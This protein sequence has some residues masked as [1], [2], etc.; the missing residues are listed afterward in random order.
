[1]SRQEK[2]YLESCRTVVNEELYLDGLQSKKRKLTTELADLQGK[3]QTSKRHLQSHKDKMQ[4]LKIA[5]NKGKQFKL[6]HARK[7]L[8]FEEKN[9]DDEI[10][11]AV[12]QALE[13]HSPNIVKDESKDKQLNFDELNQIVQ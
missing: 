1:M 9:S 2:Q 6:N 13:K 8:K 5:F 10:I 12:D 7:A 4:R 3:I 11:V